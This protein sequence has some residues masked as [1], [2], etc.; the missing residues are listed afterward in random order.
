M[1]PGS[2]GRFP[3]WHKPL[4]LPNTTNANAWFCRMISLQKRPMGNTSCG[5]A[6]AAFPLP[7]FRHPGLSAPTH[8]CPPW[9]RSCVRRWAAKN[10]IVHRISSPNLLTIKGYSSQSRMCV[11]APA[12]SARRL[13]HPQSLQPPRPQPRHSAL[14]IPNAALRRLRFPTLDLR[15]WT[16]DFART[17][18][19]SQL[20][21]FSAVNRT[22][23][24]H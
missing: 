3:L 15:L 20:A 5:K 11:R 1:P 12:P 7:R 19:A 14:R 21:A 18:S 9:N 24:P 8:P 23:G 22:S 2:C 4:P 13:A 6:K 16:L 17:V 10:W